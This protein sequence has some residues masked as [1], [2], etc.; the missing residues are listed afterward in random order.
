MNKNLKLKKIIKNLILEELPYI[1]DLDEKNKCIWDFGSTSE[2]K[3]FFD[4]EK[5]FGSTQ[6][7]FG[8]EVIIGNFLKNLF[9]KKGLG[10][11]THSGIIFRNGLVFHADSTSG[12]RFDSIKHK[13]IN[14]YPQNYIVVVIKG[15]NEKNLYNFCQKL[16][17]YMKISNLKPE[18]TYNNLGIYEQIPIIGTILHKLRIKKKNKL[19]YQCA[20]LIVFCLEQG[21]GIELGYDTGDIDVESVNFSIIV[22]PTDLYYAISEK[23][24][25]ELLLTDC[26]IIAK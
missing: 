10:A 13:E 15:T 20:E 26:N 12:V 23:T 18:D 3:I 1:A 2:I 17:N 4:V 8:K 5:F 24:N 7:F 11:A 25:S 6:S 19:A 14:D 22:S 21:A 9:N 16:Y